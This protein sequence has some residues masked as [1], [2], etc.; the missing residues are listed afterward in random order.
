MATVPMTIRE[1][2]DENYP[3]MVEEGH[4]VHFFL[5]WENNEP[6][7]VSE[8]LPGTH[9]IL[10]ITDGMQERLGFTKEISDD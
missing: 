5:T 1:I 3:M 6:I 7:S 8:R 10:T 4:E 9:K 2:F